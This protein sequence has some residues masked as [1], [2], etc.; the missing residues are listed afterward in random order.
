MAFG[1]FIKIQK[2]HTPLCLGQSVTAA[3]TCYFPDINSKEVNGWWAV[4]SRIWHLTMKL[5]IGCSGHKPTTKL[6]TEVDRRVW[7]FLFKA[8]EPQNP[9]RGALLTPLGC[10]WVEGVCLPLLAAILRSVVGSLQQP[11]WGAYVKELFDS[12]KGLRRVKCPSLHSRTTGWSWRR[13][14]GSLWAAV[15][16]CFQLGYSLV[17][18][19]GPL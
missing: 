12:S 4:M 5:L 11:E 19:K 3:L 9:F 13:T 7:I 16:V 17:G 15:G 1:G 2:I 14:G 8:V 6:D 10:G 18:L